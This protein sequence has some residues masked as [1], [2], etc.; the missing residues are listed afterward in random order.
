MG[1]GREEGEQVWFTNR[2]HHAARARGGGRWLLEVSL[3]SLL[4][5]KGFAFPY[6]NNSALKEK[7]GPCHLPSFSNFVILFLWLKVSLVCFWRVI[8]D[9][10]NIC[11]ATTKMS[12]ADRP[13]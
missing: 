13:V 10:E 2:L 3:N 9:S 1:H 4:H 7:K 8:M 6:C 12:K 5:S 11:L